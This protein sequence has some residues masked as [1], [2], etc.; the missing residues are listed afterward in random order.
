MPR[1]ICSCGE[2]MD[3]EAQRC[4]PCW[5]T[6]RAFRHLKPSE[7]PV[8]ISP[9]R[10]PRTP[11][12]SALWDLRMREEVAANRART[13]RAVNSRVWDGSLMAEKVTRGGPVRA[14]W[15]EYQKTAVYRRLIAENPG[16][17]RELWGAFAAGYCAGNSPEVFEKLYLWRTPEGEAACEQLRARYI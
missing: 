2:P 7:R 16:G 3:Y 13:T 8:K 14:A 15:R 5:R 6:E 4:W 1:P 9:E 17:E 11:G 12:G 10:N